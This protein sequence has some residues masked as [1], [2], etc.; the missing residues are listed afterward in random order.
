MNVFY[1]TPSRYLKA[2]HDAK[3]TWEVK[4]DDFFPYAHCPHC[5][6][7]GYFTSR[8]ALKAY[9]RE[10]NGMLQACKQMETLEFFDPRTHSPSSNGLRR[11]M[12]V[13]QH[14]DAVTG[15]EKQHVAFD[16]AKRLAIAR[17]ECKVSFLNK[18][19]LEFKQVFSFTN[20]TYLCFF[21]SGLDDFFCEI[22]NERSTS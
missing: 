19:S 1:S 14:H 21:P 4:T 13:N 9:I 7:T 16:Y 18:L 15:T 10:S 3:K 17:E 11:A 12:A 22:K 6:W 8:P 5:Y 20:C 2:L